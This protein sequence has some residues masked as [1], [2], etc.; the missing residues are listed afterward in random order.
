MA[1]PMNDVFLLTCATAQD[2]IRWR[3]AQAVMARLKA[4]TDQVTMLTPMR[5]GSTRLNFLCTAWAYAESHSSGDYFWIVDDN[6]PANRNFVEIGFKLL[7]AYY[8]T[9]VMIAAR[10]RA[11]P[12]STETVVSVIEPAGPTFCRK[13]I[14]GPILEAHRKEWDRANDRNFTEWILSAT[15]WR[16]GRARDLTYNDLGYKLGT[17]WPDDYESGLTQIAE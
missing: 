6:M 2:P 4:E 15:T 1:E 14:L 9:F 17:L 3:L 16:V 12:P 13:G 10:E 11:K 8:S 5:V 7:T